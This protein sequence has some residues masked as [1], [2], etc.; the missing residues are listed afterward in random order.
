MNKNDIKYTWDLSVICKNNDEFEKGLDKVKSLSNEF[1]KLYK[2]HLLDNGSILLKALKCDEVKTRLF[3]KLYIYAYLN[4]Y[5]CTIDENAKTLKNKIDDLNNLLI[6]KESWFN[7]E[8]KKITKA[9]FE[10][11]KKEEKGLKIYD[12][13]IENILRNKKHTLS[14][15][16]EELISKLNVCFNNSKKVFSSLDDSD[17]KFR[18]IKLDNK[19]YKL[20]HSTY[21]TYIKSDNRELRK[22]TFINYF[23]YYKKHKNTLA[24]LYISSVKANN[25]YSIIRKYKN[26]LDANLYSDNINERVFNNIIDVVNSNVNLLQKYINIKKKDFNIKDFNYYDLYCESNTDIKYNFD[27]AKEIILNAFKALGDD[28]TDVINK[29]FDERWIDVYYKKGKRSGAFSWG[30]YDTYPYL[31][32]N[33]NDDYNSIST[34]AHELGHSVNKYYSKKQH[35]LYSDNPIFLAEIASTV[36]E[37]LLANYMLSESKNKEEKKSILINLLEHFRTTIFRQVLFSEFEKEIYDKELNNEV[38]T[39]K[40]LTDTYFNITKKYYKDSIEYFDN[41]KYEWSRIPHFYTP[42]YVYKYATG[43]C[44]ASAIVNDIVSDKKDAVERYKEFLSSGEKDY[45]LNILKECGYNLNNKKIF[46]SAMKL[47][48]KYIKEYEKLVNFKN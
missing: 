18:D 45:P 23:D 44:V 12:F 11:F 21:G 27:K 6:E 35:Y 17:V 3:N 10:E 36:N 25:K 32:L 37:L 30:D 28:Y 8:L 13:Y 46:E 38:L 24:E 47:F 42:F 1:N 4:F 39:E 34:L 40:V 20:N 22:Q 19:I 41:Y 7:I 9:K 14:R 2:G 43:M 5:A 16:E 48:D 31:L 15:K 29:A 26:T 33:Y